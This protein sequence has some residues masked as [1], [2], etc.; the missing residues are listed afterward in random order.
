MPGQEMR[1]LL[2]EVGTLGGRFR[3]G[4]IEMPTH[5]APILGLFDRC[6][7]S[8]GAVRSR[9]RARGRDARPPLLTESLLLA[10]LAAADETRRGSLVMGSWNSALGDVEGPLAQGAGA[11]R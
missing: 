6:R 8:F 1:A 5:L 11:R 7:S 9:L 2:D 10:E 4:A 3:H